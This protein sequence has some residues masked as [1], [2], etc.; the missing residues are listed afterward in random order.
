MC[1]FSS[2]Y[3]YIVILK[4]KYNGRVDQ[5]GGCVVGEL[6]MENTDITKAILIILKMNQ[7]SVQCYPT[8]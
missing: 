8:T 7:G 3:Q 4:V 5:G 1:A 2:L 6:T